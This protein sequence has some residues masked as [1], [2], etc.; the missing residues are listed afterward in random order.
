MKPE[1][2][3]KKASDEAI[4]KMEKTAD[5]RG[6][7]EARN[8]SERRYGIETDA[9]IVSHVPSSIAPYARL[10]DTPRPRSDRGRTGPDI[11][12]RISSTVI[13]D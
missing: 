7:S 2:L 5:G 11:S 3:R 8:Q 12:L 9:E 10:R 1:E 6:V 4:G 13:M